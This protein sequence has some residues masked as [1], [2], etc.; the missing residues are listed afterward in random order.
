MSFKTRAAIISAS[1]VNFWKETSILITQGLNPF[2]AVRIFDSY[3]KPRVTYCMTIWFHQNMISLDKMWWSLQK[4]IFGIRNYQ[5]SKHVVSVLS[6]IWPP[7]L[8]YTNQE[9]MFLHSTAR[10][11]DILNPGNLAIIPQQINMVR[12]F[13][14]HKLSIVNR[15]PDEI[16]AIYIQYARQSSVSTFKKEVD[17]YCSHLWQRKIKQGLM[18][19]NYS[20]LKVRNSI[21]KMLAP[22]P[23][24]V[25]VKTLRVLMNDFEVREVLFRSKKSKTDICPYCRVVDD[26]AHYLFSCVSYQEHRRSFIKELQNQNIDE[27]LVGLLN[28]EN[29]HVINALA[30]FIASIDLFL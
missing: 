30:G 1:V 13:L 14:V 11:P 29:K 20:G 21:M 22:Y 7:S 8:L 18:Y 6:N 15:D 2:Y 12:L 25:S 28:C 9:L 19:S 23:R 10:S 5:V 16:K 26:T 4:S 24:K 27:T 3:V 17:K